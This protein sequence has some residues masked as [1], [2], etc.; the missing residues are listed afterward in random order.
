MTVRHAFRTKRIE[1]QTVLAVRPGHGAHKREGA[2]CAPRIQVG[3]PVGE[4]AVRSVHGRYDSIFVDG[5]QNWDITA[6][7]AGDLVPTLRVG[8]KIGAL[9]HGTQSVRGRSHAER[10]NEGGGR[11]RSHAPRGNAGWRSAP[12]DAE[13]PRAFPRGAWE[14]GGVG[15]RGRGNEGSAPR[16]AERPR[17][18]PRSAWERGG[19][20]TRGARI[21]LLRPCV[22][23]ALWRN[24]PDDWGAQ[25]N[26][27]MIRTDSLPAGRAANQAALPGL[28]ARTRRA[29][30]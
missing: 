8:M 7:R 24:L 5:G 12:R 15:T 22:T 26:N 1:G 23:I 2:S 30:R 20:G 6:E 19:V 16:D 13:R 17:A 9:R 21:A 14:R 28:L 3:G 18:F 25:P 11:S 10:G 27:L 29:A 4:G